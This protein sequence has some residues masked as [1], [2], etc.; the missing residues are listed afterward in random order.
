MLFGQ[1]YINKVCQELTEKSRLSGQD[2]LLKIFKSR[3]NELPVYPEIIV[4]NYYNLT[5]VVGNLLLKLLLN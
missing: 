2:R 1:L 3:A 5:Y 4:L